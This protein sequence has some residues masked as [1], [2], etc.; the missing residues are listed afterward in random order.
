VTVPAGAV[1]SSD[2]SL[3]AH[4]NLFA[5]DELRGRGKSAAAVDEA[6]YEVGLSEVGDAKVR[7]SSLGMRQRLGL[8]AALLTEP[9]L[10]VLDEPANGLEPAGKR[11][12]RDWL[13][14][15]GSPGPMRCPVAR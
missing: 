14:G 2:P 13:R 9:R 4:Q 15:S 8:A 11:H 5:Q 6:L 1:G 10:L 12:V 3:T 7:G